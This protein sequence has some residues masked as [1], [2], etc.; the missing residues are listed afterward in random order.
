MNGPIIIGTRRSITGLINNPQPRRSLARWSGSSVRPAEQNKRRRR[1]E[2][3]PDLRTHTCVC[4]LFTQQPGRVA[5]VTWT[6]IHLSFGAS[7][8]GGGLIYGPTGAGPVW[9]H[10]HSPFPTL[11]Q[12]AVDKLRPNCGPVAKTAPPAPLTWVNKAGASHKPAWC[13][14]GRPAA[15]GGGIFSCG[16][17]SGRT[18]GRVNGNSVLLG[19][20]LQTCPRPGKS[21]LESPEIRYRSFCKHLNWD[22]LVKNHIKTQLSGNNVT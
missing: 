6:L 22:R 19:C 21:V 11:S 1:R 5:C 4:V 2:P 8:S 12:L 9:S 20:C 3:P 15:A 13:P 7:V 14:A 10:N 17:P 16:K 18:G